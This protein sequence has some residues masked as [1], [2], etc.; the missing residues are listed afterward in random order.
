MSETL[1]IHGQVVLPEG[2]SPRQAAELVV[3]VEDISRADAPSIVL[4]EDRQRDVP[5]EGGG[6]VPFTIEVPADRV[7]PRSLYSVQAHIDA[8]G[9]G[10]VEP[11]DLISTR[12][13]P[14]LTRGY[15]HEA[16]IDVQPV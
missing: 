7:D 6:T 12:S 4:A 15:G 13:Y 5:L 16:T 2:S 10:D 1:V 9:S 11:G 3:R 8:T 14:V